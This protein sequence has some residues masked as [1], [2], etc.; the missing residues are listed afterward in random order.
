MNMRR[1]EVLAVELQASDDALLSSLHP[2]VRSVLLASG[3]TGPHL[4]FFSRLLSESGYKQREELIRDLLAG[5]P[6]TGIIPVEKSSKPL[7]VQKSS[8]DVTALPRGK[9][10]WERTIKKHVRF[11]EQTEAYVK[12]E[13]WRQT[14]EEQKVGRITPFEEFNFQDVVPTR[15]FGVTQQS[16]KGTVKVRCI[17]DFHESEVNDT[18]DVVGRIRMGH[19]RDLAEQAKIFHRHHPDEDL[20]IWKSDFKGAYR[21]VPIHPSQQDFAKIL[22]FD[23]SSGRCHVARQLAMPFGSIAAVYA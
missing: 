22:V 2:D 7:E 17:D 3:D 13:I 19:I 1:L 9:A 4:A 6:L 14:I 23:P 11:S 21:S 5:F 8:I 16:S 12:E 10:R 18:C 20:V 15:R